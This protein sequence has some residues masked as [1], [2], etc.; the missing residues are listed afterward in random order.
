[1]G[2]FFKL[3]NSKILIALVSMAI[4]IPVSVVTAQSSFASPPLSCAAGGACAKGDIGPGGG[5]V[6]FI[7][8]IESP[9]F[10][11]PGGYGSAAP[12]SPNCSL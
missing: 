5:T 11:V 2:K 7:A 8:P 1:M 12:C 10:S 4:S 3:G 6:F 9:T